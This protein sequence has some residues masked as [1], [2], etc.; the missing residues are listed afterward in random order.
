MLRSRPGREKRGREAGDRWI[1]DYVGNCYH[2]TCD[3]WDPEWDLRGAAQDIALFH[4]IAE[5]LGNSARWPRWKSGS[6]FQA[7]REASAELRR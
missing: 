7:I 2:Q 4:L 3:A 6:E 5:D 1:A